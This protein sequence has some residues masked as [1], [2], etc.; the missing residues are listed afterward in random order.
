LVFVAKDDAVLSWRMGL[1]SCSARL[2]A[3]SRGRLSA[4]V[5]RN[6]DAGKT[7]NFVKA[8][9]SVDAGGRDDARQHGDEDGVLVAAYCPGEEA[10]IENNLSVGMTRVN[11]VV[12]DPE[13]VT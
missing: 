8:V 10:P 13:L 6:S 5:S 4:V 12:F 9:G 2:G 11:L 3:R 1:A 7:V